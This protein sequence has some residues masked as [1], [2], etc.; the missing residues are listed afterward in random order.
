MIKMRNNFALIGCGFFSPNHLHAWQEMSLR[1][2]LVAVCDLDKDRAVAIAKQFNVPQIYTDAE[3][4]LRLEELDFV[5]IATTAP[6]H[7]SIIEICAK[8]GVA[9]IVQKPLAGSW[10]DALASVEAMEKSGLPFMVHENFR[11][12]SPIRRAA[13]LVDSGALGDI[14]WGQFSF[15]TGFDIYENQPYL[16]SVERF[17]LLDLGIHVLDIAR[18]FMGEADSVYCSAQ[19]VKPGIRGEDVATVMLTHKYGATSVVDISYASRLDPDPFP[20]TLVHIEGSRGSLKIGSGCRLSVTTE[21][22]SWQETVDPRPLSWGV[23]PW[24]LTQDSM[25]KIQEHWLDCLDTNMVPQTSGD[26]NLKT[27]ALVEAAY[28]SASTGMPIRP[29]ERKV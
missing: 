17:A 6:S 21:N 2:N 28:L 9:A 5:D 15:R 14:F 4:M 27:F 16:A 22:K 10:D 18:V 23:E 11:F 20:Q 1:A 7:R 19:S 26:D 29:I 8:L 25:V 3:E 13:D 24:L 12:Q